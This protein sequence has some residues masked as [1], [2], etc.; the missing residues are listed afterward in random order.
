M[1]AHFLVG[2]IQNGVVKDA[3][4]GQAH[5]AQTL[6]DSGVVKRADALRIDG[7]HSRAFLHFNHKDVAVAAQTHV[8][9]KARAIER[10]NRG[11]AFGACEFIAHLE[12]QVREHRTGFSTG[13]TLDSNIFDDKI[14][15][16]RERDTRD[17]QERG[18]Y[19]GAQQ[20][21][22]KTHFF[23]RFARMAYCISLTKSLERA[24]APNAKT[25]KSP[26]FWPACITDSGRGRPR[27]ISSK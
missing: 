2:A 1:A 20:G 15:G 5:I 4:F 19:R 21:R 26:T 9:E 14:G 11:V 6:F 10:V 13:N 23:K 22:S 8:A 25:I 27:T 12:R 7:S 18:R 3:A 16:C 24:K 17:R